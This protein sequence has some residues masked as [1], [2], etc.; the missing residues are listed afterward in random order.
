MA[1]IRVITEF[2]DK[3][4]VRVIVYVYDDTPKLVAPTKVLVSIWDPDGGVPVVDNE[5]IIVSG[6]IEDGIY[7]YFYHKGDTSEPMDAGRW[8]GEVLVIDGSGTGA[9]ISPG[10]FSFRIK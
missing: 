1:K 9:I 2:P 7:Q 4:T 3:A 10:N 6:K 5:D 8:R